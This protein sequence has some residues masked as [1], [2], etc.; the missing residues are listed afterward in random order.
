MVKEQINGFRGS[1]SFM[2]GI[3]MAILEK[4]QM[5]IKM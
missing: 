5:M 2:E 4:Q 1:H 3:K